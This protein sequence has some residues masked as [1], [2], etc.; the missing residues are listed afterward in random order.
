MKLERKMGL[1]IHSKKTKHMTVKTRK[2]RLI[3]IEVKIKTNSYWNVQ[4]KIKTTP[5]IKKEHDNGLV[6]WKKKW[7]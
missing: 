3:T 5:Q 7:Q 1:K 2:G 6:T 4:G